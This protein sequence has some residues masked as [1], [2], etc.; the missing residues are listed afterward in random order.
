MKIHIVQKGETLWKIAQ[1]YN[2][3]FNKLKEMN[4]HLSNPENIMPGMKIKV[5]T[6]SKPV[7]KEQQQGVQQG[8]KKEK[9]KEVQKEQPKET[10][11][12][13]E[14][15][16]K[17]K[18]PEM[19]PVVKEDD[20][21]FSL[22]VDKAMLPFS[23]KAKMPQQTK[24]MDIP[25]MP[26]IPKMEY[27]QDIHVHVNEEESSSSDEM[28]HMHHQVQHHAAMPQYHVP[29]HAPVH[30][31]QVPSY[32]PCGCGGT[33][34]YH[35]PVYPATH[36]HGH[37]AGAQHQ[38][39]PGYHQMPTPAVNTHHTGHYP[40]MEL[41][42]ESSSLEIPEMP[43]HMN[44]HDGQ[45][46]WPTNMQGMTN[47]QPLTQ[48]TNQVPVQPWVGYPQTGTQGYPQQQAYAGYPQQGVPQYQ[49]QQG[50]MGYPQAGVPMYHPQ[51]GFH[52]Q[53][54]M[55]Q[56][57]GYQQNVPQYQQPPYPTRDQDEE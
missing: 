39:Y 23:G 56:Q 18:S 16:Y 8:T 7:K 50:Y 1:K 35:M 49:Q 54:G 40:E 36:H 55:A 20:N 11:P 25:S 6:Q 51:Y 3:D 21:D 19:Y 9:K 27:E 42:E 46:N 43:D 34:T 38:A 12:Q 31:Y 29:Y 52:P 24:K 33:P 48:T 4:T 37:V 14:H 26:K 13:A 15:P 22:D 44:V 28:H 57:Y 45:N 30:Y 41:D 47:Q 5:P 2:V 32:N 53:L 10:A 17:D